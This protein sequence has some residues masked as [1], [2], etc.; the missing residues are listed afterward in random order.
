MRRRERVLTAVRKINFVSTVPSR[1]E[2][3]LA[4]R[5]NI[6][7]SS[8]LGSRSSRPSSGKLAVWPTAPHNS[9]S[10]IV[11]LIEKTDSDAKSHASCRLTPSC[12]RSIILIHLVFIT[13]I[14]NLII[15]LHTSNR[16]LTLSSFLP[17]STRKQTW[18]GE[19]RRRI[20]ATFISF[21]YPQAYVER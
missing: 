4:R 10:C 6:K 1:S 8:W 5:S 7:P 16:D 14:K 15:P 18:Q 19:A 21:F 12:P 11:S 13:W 3:E 2:S 9:D 17:L 20:S